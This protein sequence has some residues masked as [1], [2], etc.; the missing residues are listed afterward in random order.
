MVKSSGSAP[1]SMRPGQ[2]SAQAIGVRMSGA[3]SCAITE[4]S[5]YSTIEW[6]TLCGCTT[7]WIA[8]SGAPKSQWASITSRPLFIIVAES[9]E[10]FGP[11]TQL[12][13]ATACCGVTRAR[14]S[15]GAA[16]RRARARPRARR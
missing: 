8:S 13:W 1:D 5:R 6:T 15:A 16:R 4:P 2:A 14:R 11:I 12:G 9:T 3:P 7:I 10:I